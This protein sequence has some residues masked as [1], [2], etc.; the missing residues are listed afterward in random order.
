MKAEIIEL[1]KKLVLKYQCVILT[2]VFSVLSSHVRLKDY[3]EERGFGDADTLDEIESSLQQ[4]HAF[5]DLLKSKGYVC[6]DVL[7]GD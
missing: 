2:K 1:K 7:D 5:L 4:F 6:R 3:Q